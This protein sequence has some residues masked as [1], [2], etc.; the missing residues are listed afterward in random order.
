M[1]SFCTLYSGSSGNL[2]YI[3]SDNTK[4]LIDCGVSGRKAATSLSNIGIDAQDIDGILVTHEHR[5]H[6]TGVGVLSRRYDIP[7]YANEKTWQAIEPIIGEVNTCNK[8]KI[9]SSKKFYIKDILVDAF[10]IPHD[11][12]DPVGYS[13]NIDKI[14]ISL[15]TDI[16]YVNRQLVEKFY[17]S[18]MM[19]IESNH[20]EE[21]LKCG[22]YPYYLKRRILGRRGH[23]SNDIAGKFV[24]YMYER[25]TKQFLLGH[26]SKENNFPELA[27]K[28]VYN[29]L[30]EKRIDV[31][32]EITLDVAYRDKSSKVYS[33]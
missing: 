30:K 9:Q 8:K 24:A 5:D 13:F 25:G 1:I 16:G 15:A 26:L 14:K 19:L 2:I 3:S 11:A 29:I 28:T 4:L 7:I 23:L 20:D 32:N 27:Y 6:I 10:D 33:L 12:V 17:G 18:H 31:E 22:S 21:M